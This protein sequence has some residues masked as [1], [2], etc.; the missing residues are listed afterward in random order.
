L[1]VGAPKR[2]GDR[3]CTKLLPS[4]QKRYSLYT[5]M[6]FEFDPQK[7]ERNLAKHGIDFVDAQQL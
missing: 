1:P 7:S 6:G 5:I 4:R 3:H 2:K